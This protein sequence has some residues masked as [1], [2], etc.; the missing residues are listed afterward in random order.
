M[1]HLVLGPIVRLQIQRSALKIGEKPQRRYDPGAIL[2]TDRLRV[3]PDGA[4]A[5][6]DGQEIVDVHHRGHPATRNH[7]GRNSLSVGFT[8]HYAA[9]RDRYGNHM[10]P[11]CAGENILVD[12]ARRVTPEEARHGFVIHSEAG[13][14]RL[15]L[16]RVSVAAPC[17]PFSG[18]AH[19]HEMVEPHV[20]KET[21]QFLDGGTRGYYCSV[22]D[23]GEAVIQVGDVVALAE[24]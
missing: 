1:S 23:A 14:R 16:G 22:G 20:L 21:L 18:F 24:K 12:V 15:S 13:K 5:L 9:M 3:G 10:T 2:A 11:G 19:Q 17:R 8:S 7:E 6:V 4:V